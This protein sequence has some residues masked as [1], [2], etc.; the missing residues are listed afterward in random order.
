LNA[1]RFNILGHFKFIIIQNHNYRLPH[2][3][4]SDVAL[5]GG[6]TPLGIPFLFHT[7]GCMPTFT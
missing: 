3:S 4:S 7:D 6:V 5:V 2:Q 1:P